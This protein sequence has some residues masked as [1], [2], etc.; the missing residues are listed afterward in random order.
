MNT[1]TFDSVNISTTVPSWACPSGWNCGDIGHPLLSGSELQ[2][3]NSLILQGAGNDIWNA[4]DQFHFVWQTLAADGSVSAH[5]ISQTNTSSWAK[6]GVMLRQST[7]A[8]SP[9]YAVLVTPG[10]GII[11]QYR[12]TL[13]SNTQQPVAFLGTVPAYLMV[14]RS[15]N[16]YTAY[17][18]TDGITWTPV[19]G[20]NVTLN[21]SGPILAGLA[22]T[23]HNDGVVSDAAFDTVSIGTLACPISWNCADIGSPAPAGSQS[24]SGNTWTIQGGGN[25]IWN[26]ADQ[27]HFVW[28]TLAADGSVS[29]HVLSQTN[30][31]VWAKAGVMLRQSTDAGSPFYDIVV[32][33]GNGI[34]VQYRATQGASA[35]QLVDFTGTV[36]TYLMVTRTGST[37][38]AY[39]ST[40]GTI[41]TLVAGSNVTFNLSGPYR[42]VWPLLRTM[43]EL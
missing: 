38:T 21:L 36:P 40:D 29:A 10:N 25:D 39:T 20:S 28:Q 35:Q 17:T 12:T 3:G 5:I 16:T 41:W 43:G 19:A 7:D 37:Y 9:Y 15:G 34:T 26:A 23:S 30:T 18:S 8:A 42:R 4:A 31:S 11:V 33:P 24:L 1:A 32:T 27:F 22:V 14:A 6:A 2:N 13:G